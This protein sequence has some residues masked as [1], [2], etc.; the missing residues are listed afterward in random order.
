[1]LSSNQ[2]SY[3]GF[4]IWTTAWTTFFDYRK[5]DH[6]GYKTTL[7]FIALVQHVKF[8]SFLS[9]CIHQQMHIDSQQNTKHLNTRKIYASTEFWYLLHKYTFQQTE[10]M[11]PHIQQLL[12][13]MNILRSIDDWNNMEKALIN[14]DDTKSFGV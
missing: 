10:P 7:I 14:S 8:A 12:K 11:L 4:N 1:M 9:R 5:E 2:L 13:V 6:L 3:N